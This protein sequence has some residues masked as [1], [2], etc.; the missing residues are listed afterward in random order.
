[1]GFRLVT[2]PLVSLR[3]RLAL[4]T[5]NRQHIVPLLNLV[6][7]LVIS[8]GVWEVIMVIPVFVEIR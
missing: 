6:R 2:T 7:A 5:P 1:M 8:L 3:V 4:A